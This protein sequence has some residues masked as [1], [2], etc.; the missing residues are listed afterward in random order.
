M[1]LAT[2]VIDCRDHSPASFVPNKSLVSYPGVIPGSQATTR[3]RAAGGRG[4]AFQVVQHTISGRGGKF[5]LYVACQ[6]TGK[7]RREKMLSWQ[8]IEHG[9]P[10]TTCEAETRYYARDA[11]T[12]RGN[13][14]RL[15][16][17]CNRREQHC[18]RK[19][20]MCCSSY[21]SPKSKPFSPA[22]PPLVIKREYC[23]APGRRRPS[24]I[25]TAGPGKARTP[26]A[27][28][29]TREPENHEL[30]QDEC[31]LL[32]AYADRLGAGLRQQ[33]CPNLPPP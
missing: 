15:R 13:S 12:E 28:A 23:Y 17:V 33:G 7:D 10:A 19:T 31:S 32:L 11:P 9:I 6:R 25:H 1:Q 3:R 2:M 24:L 30:T 5:H 27:E 26:A 8:L 4:R 21:M 20:E 29:P 16:S 14:I 18:Q 22:P